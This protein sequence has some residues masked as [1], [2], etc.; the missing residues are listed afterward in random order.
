MELSLVLASKLLSM[1][2]YVLVGYITV[3]TGIL[4]SD[5]SRILSRLTVW[6]VQPCMILKAFQI[7]LT[8][9]RIKGF[10]ACLILTFIVY[11]VW[12]SVTALAKKPLHLDP[13]DQTTLI[14]SNVGNLI[15]PLVAMTLGDE[16]VFYGSCIQIP[17]NLL[18]WTH[19]VSVIRGEKTFHLR[20]ILLNPNIIALF[21]GL[22]F[23]LLK[24][25]LPGVLQTSV[26]GLSQMVAPM[27][28]LVVGM[29]IAQTDLKS[30]FTYR[31]AYGILV[32]R[33]ILYPLMV[34]GLLYAS[35]FL[36]RYPQYVP[37]FLIPILSFAAPPSSTISQLSVVYDVEPLEAGIYNVMGALFCII[38]MPL[39]VLCYQFLFA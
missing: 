14:Y 21:T 26:D 36:H 10:I 32:G 23:L 5:D 19:G 3:R 29:V 16:M 15:L 24:V 25:R 1:M 4:K 2:I 38:T 35:G 34:I 11:A 13:I 31:K 20:K 18:T 7:E 33:L 37:F 12:I 27:S 30:V 17:F 28:M 39:I 8:H 6:I 9:E 22:I